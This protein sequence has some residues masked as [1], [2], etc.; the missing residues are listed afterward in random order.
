M[1]GLIFDEEKHLY[2]F[3]GQEVKSV[4]QILKARGFIDDR[5]FTEES[6][7]R[8]QAV[9]AACHYLDE[10]DLDW[11]TLDPIVVPYVRAY[12]KFK[13]EHGFIPHLMEHRVF[14]PTYMYAGT[15][16]R[17][18]WINER[19]VLLD[20]KSGAISP[21]VGLQ[22]AG[23]GLCLKKRLPRIALRLKADE[24]YELREF[25]DPADYDIFLM[26]VSTHHW[27]TNNMKGEIYGSNDTE[28]Y[29]AA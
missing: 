26:Q 18:G 8:G 13:I 27:I 15:L 4:T 22:L 9:H 12:E 28:L 23:Y 25:K 7:A 29:C 20:F 1:N 19:E 10:E 24:T 6:R 11:D 21:W 2:L 14:N 3:K 5:W 16:D 17:T